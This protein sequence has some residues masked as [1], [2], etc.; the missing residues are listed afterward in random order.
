MFHKVSKVVLYDRCNTFARFS[1]DGLHVS[2][3]A[4]HFGLVLRVFADRIVRA[5][6]SIVKW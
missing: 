4:Q 1:E 3:Q 2:Q 6:S 5:P